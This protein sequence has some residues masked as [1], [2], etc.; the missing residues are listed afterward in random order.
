MLIL[1]VSILGVFGTLAITQWVKDAEEGKVS[2]K[3]IGSVFF[4]CV[5]LLLLM[6]FLGWRTD[7]FKLEIS[8]IF[9][10]SMA[11]IFLIT[12][13]DAKTASSHASLDEI[14]D[15]MK[16]LISLLIVTYLLILYMEYPET[17]QEFQM[18][19]IIIATHIIRRNF[20]SITNAINRIWIR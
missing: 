12:A 20:K 5:P 17:K 16:W 1:F 7:Y 2:P 6:G 3:N 15:W 11:G 4:S 19:S 18:M 8:I 13:I 10:M 9:Y 14:K